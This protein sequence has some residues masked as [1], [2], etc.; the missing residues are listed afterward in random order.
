MPHRDYL[1]A[2]MPAQVYRPGT[3]PAYSNYAISLAGY[4]VERLTQSAAPSVSRAAHLSAAR[5]DE[6]HLRAAAPGAARAA[7]IQ[8]LSRREQ[9][10]EAIRDLQC[11]R[12]PARCRPRASD[13]ARFMIAVL[14]GGTHRR[15]DDSAARDAR[16]MQT[17]QNETHADL[18][19]MGLGFMEYSQNGRTIWGHGGDTMSFSQ[20]PVPDPGRARRRLHFLQQRGLEAWQRAGRSATRVFRA[21]FPG[22]GYS[23]E[24]VERRCERGRAVSGVYEVS[25]R[26][27]TNWMQ[28]HGAAWPD[29]GEVGCRRRADD[30]ERSRT[31][32]DSRNAGGK[33]RPYSYREIDGPDRLAFR[34][35][36]NGKVTELLPNVPIYVA[37]RVSG[38][39]S[40]TVLFPLVGGSL[41]FHRGDAAPVAIC[42][43][44]A[45]TLSGARFA[46][47]RDAGAASAGAHRLSAHR[48]NARGARVAVHAK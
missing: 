24:A 37:Q 22:R 18:R 30:S 14:N 12:R 28:H 9:T 41:G 1:L 23:A 3:T 6:L 8:R 4:I 16:Q 45:E 5:D 40:K 42:R 26:S 38:F 31:C 17:R 39:R 33:R 7:L 15:R 48:R 11:Q 20:R 44:G 47:P 34:R 25:R 10:T 36:A 29:H 19:A 35:D 43:D 13:M 2:H 32:A 21:L 46:E 27:E